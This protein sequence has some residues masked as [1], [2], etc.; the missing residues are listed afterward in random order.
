MSFS[1]NSRTIVRTVQ[2]LKNPQIICAHKAKI[3]VN[4]RVKITQSAYADQTR[5]FLSCSNILL[6][7]I[8]V[9]RLHGEDYIILSETVSYILVT[10]IIKFLPLITTIW[11]NLTQTSDNEAFA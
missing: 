3:H 9:P 7:M 8:K 11:I 6:S 2:S 1:A 10:I 5:S 4:M